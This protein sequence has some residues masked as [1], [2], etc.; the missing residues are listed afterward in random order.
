[1]E[2]AAQQAGLRTIVTSHTFVEKA[3]L[4]L[5]ETA[6]IVWLEEIRS[7][8]GA[9]DRFLALLL[10]VFAPISLLE[11]IAGAT[12]RPTMDD[13]ATI[14]FSSG[15]TGDP[16]GIMLTHFNLDSNVE[17]VAQV[18]QVGP[19]DRLLG[20]LPFFHSFGYLAN[21]TAKRWGS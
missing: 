7:S 11:R 14:V 13:L 12:R 10:A 20:I 5:P 9:G 6:A 8:I 17:G 1:M 21:T 18:L 19:D 2:S 3:Q 16:K 4:E 15:S